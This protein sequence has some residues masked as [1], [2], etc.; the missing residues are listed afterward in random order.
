MPGDNA[1]PRE[2]TTEAVPGDLPDEKQILA[3]EA[4]NPP[5]LVATSPCQMTLQWKEL[6]LKTPQTP[7]QPA[8][9]SINFALMMK[10]VSLATSPGLHKL[11]R[12]VP[13]SKSLICA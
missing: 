10:L 6:Q 12:V 5:T 11:E 3:F 2:G 4:P 13:G 9:V 1:R 8:G 7:L